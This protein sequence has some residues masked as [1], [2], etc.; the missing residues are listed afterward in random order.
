[1][2]KK[3]IYQLGAALVLLALVLIFLGVNYVPRIYAVSSAGSSVVVAGKQTRILLHRRAL[4]ASNCFAAELCW[5]RL[6]RSSPLE[7]LQQFGLGRAPSIVAK[8]I[9][10]LKRWH[11]Q[12][13]RQSPEGVFF[14]NS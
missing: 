6:D 1:M 3:S 12:V 5:I 4:S 8:P 7:L 2:S 11:P 14:L 9:K 13:H 10:H